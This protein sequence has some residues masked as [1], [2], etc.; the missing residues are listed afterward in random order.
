MNV[1]AA[2]NETEKHKNVRIMI[3]L[4]L[5]IN[6]QTSDTPEYFSTENR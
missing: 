2:A 6:S 4:K 5:F 1:S 3:L